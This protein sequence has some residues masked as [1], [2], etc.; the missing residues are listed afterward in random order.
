MKNTT[1][2]VV[3]AVVVTARRAARWLGGLSS[4]Q[5]S[6][7]LV[8]GLLALATSASAEGDAFQ[9]GRAL[10]RLLVRIFWG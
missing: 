4:G 5:K 2:R 9:F 6:V 1:K 10:G 7:L 8:T 3:A